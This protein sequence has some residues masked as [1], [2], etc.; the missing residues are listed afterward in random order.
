MA[1]Y[2]VTGID[3]SKKRV[4]YPMT[5]DGVSDGVFETRREADWAL[6]RLVIRGLEDLKIEEAE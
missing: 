1:G 2:V 4:R 5:P 3:R 6:Q